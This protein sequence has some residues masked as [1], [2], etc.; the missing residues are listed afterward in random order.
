MG[1]SGSLAMFWK[2]DVDLGLVSFL[3]IILKVST[4]LMGPL[5]SCL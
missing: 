1:H 5:A 2:G 3:A 4:S